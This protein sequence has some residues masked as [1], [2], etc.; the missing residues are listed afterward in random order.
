M[1]LTRQDVWDK[2]IETHKERNY[3]KN[4]I[5]TSEDIADIWSSYTYSATISP[6][7]VDLIKFR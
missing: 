3:A 2:L 1:T 4:K 7:E 6:V 5:C